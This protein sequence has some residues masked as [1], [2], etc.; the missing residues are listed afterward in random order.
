VATQQLFGSNPSIWQRGNL[1]KALWIHQL[2][3]IADPATQAFL[4]IGRVL[5]YRQ[6]P[7]K[8]YGNLNKQRPAGQRL[9]SIPAQMHSPEMSPPTY[10]TL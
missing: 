5:A 2:S 10:K 1:P 7:D 6:R 8:D 9:M 4:N 3:S